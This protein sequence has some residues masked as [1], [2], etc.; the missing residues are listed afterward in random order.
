M[1][2]CYTLSVFQHFSQNKKNA[3]VFIFRKEREFALPEHDWYCV[4]IIRSQQEF[5]KDSLIQQNDICYNLLFKN[6][7]SFQVL[8]SIAINSK[9][10]QIGFRMY[11]ITKC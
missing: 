6:L 11:D 3:F 10:L 4:C 5:N 8:P 9:C 1:K 2:L 7:C